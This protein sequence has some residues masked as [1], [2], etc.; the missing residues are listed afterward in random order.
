M[1]EYARACE[2][3][4]AHQ[5]RETASQPNLINGPSQR[6]KRGLLRVLSRGSNLCRASS[7]GVLDRTIS[8]PQPQDSGTSNVSLATAGGEAPEF[9]ASGL[10][11]RPTMP[12]G[13]SLES[14]LARLVE[15]EHDA[16]IESP[17]MV[18][19]ESGSE[20]EISIIEHWQVCTN[21]F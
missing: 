14:R 11:P 9:C 16:Y 4:T 6:Q 21:T 17:T 8:D 12:T 15:A 7:L 18:G 5:L 13:T 3:A 19:A 20:N 1:L 10:E 2:A